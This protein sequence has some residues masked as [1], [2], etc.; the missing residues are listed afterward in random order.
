MLGCEARKVTKSGNLS[1][2][3]WRVGKP[4]KLRI[5]ATPNILN[6][7]KTLHTWLISIRLHIFRIHY[8]FARS[9][10]HYFLIFISCISF[11]I[12]GQC[13]NRAIFG[14]NWTEVEGDWPLFSSWY[15]TDGVV[16]AVASRAS[17]KIST[18]S[19]ICSIW[20]VETSTSIAEKRLSGCM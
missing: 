19:S 10:W 4:G 13:Q 15:K 1:L 9:F 5:P 14:A 12:K 18:F 16:S 8:S 3:N 11:E 17:N 2:K 7:S 20:V 6:F